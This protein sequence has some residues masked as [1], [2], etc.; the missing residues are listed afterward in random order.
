LVQKIEILK[1]KKGEDNSPATR[2][3]INTQRPD[4]TQEP[5]IQIDN[6]AE[7]KMIIQNMEEEKKSL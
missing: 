7:Y 6:S 2:S 4:L 5:M 1:I 3:M